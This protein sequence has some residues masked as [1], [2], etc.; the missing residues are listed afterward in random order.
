LATRA[1]VIAKRIL[2]P[3]LKLIEEGKR[4]IALKAELN[5]IYGHARQQV[6]RELNLNFDYG[7]IGLGKEG[8]LLLHQYLQDNT[9]FQEL[10]TDPAWRNQG[11]W[12]RKVEQR[13]LWW[14]LSENLKD[15]H[16]QF[17]APT[18]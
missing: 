8:W 16:R 7:R 17:T 15:L 5:K 11:K 10:V 14:Q 2:N 6:I 12:I 4:L 18:N 3:E 13:E 1:Q 9:R